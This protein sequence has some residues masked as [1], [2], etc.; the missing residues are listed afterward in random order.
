MHWQLWRIGIASLV[1]AGC[2]SRPG[3][4]RPPSVDPDD[5]ASTA[6]EQF[7]ANRDGALSE[8]EWKSSPA[9]AAVLGQYDTSG[10]RIL[11]TDEIAE[12]IRSWQ[13]GPVGVRVVPFKISYNGRPLMGAT[14]TLMP[15][16]F[17]GDAVKPAS[18][19]S[20]QL[21]AGKLSLATEDLPKNAPNMPLVQ[22]GLYRVEITHPSLK[23]PEKYNSQT[24]LGIEISGNNP[25]PQGVTWD[26][27]N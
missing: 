22:P 17:L 8:D 24:T 25:G 21:G 12:G 5:V 1:I 19:E 3:A 14:V 26:L 27:K 4:I 11:S 6:I 10:D 16:E 9:L 2:N 15:A 18:G 20:G 13:S 23:I 7:D